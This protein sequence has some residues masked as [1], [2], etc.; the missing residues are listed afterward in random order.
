MGVGL[1]YFDSPEY[2]PAVNASQL[3]GWGANQQYADN[4]FLPNLGGLS[5]FFEGGLAVG[6][7]FGG[8]GVGFANDQD[9]KEYKPTA[10]ANMTW[11]KGNHTFKWG[12]EVVVEGFPTQSSSRANALYGF[13]GNETANPWEY[14]STAPFLGPSNVAVFGSGFPYASF[15]LGSVDSLNASAITDT[16]HG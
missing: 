2:P 4:R 12:G 16:R 13:S 6:G 14:T 3:L 1:L 11:V 10:N 15:L 5:S 9:E 8:P 7:L